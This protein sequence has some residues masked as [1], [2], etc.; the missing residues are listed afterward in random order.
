MYVQIFQTCNNNWQTSPQEFPCVIEED[1]HSA[2]EKL[3][4]LSIFS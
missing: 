4:V 3:Q 1:L 2:M